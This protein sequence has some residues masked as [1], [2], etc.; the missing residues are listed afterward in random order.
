MN[1]K[2]KKG[3]KTNLK[4][5][6]VKIGDAFSFER[7]ISIADLKKFADLS[8]DQN[9]LHL[10]AVYAGKTKFGKPIAHGM[11]LAGLFSALVG[12]FCPGKRGIYLSQSISF[13][14]PVYVDEKVTVRGEVVEKS[15]SAKIV[16]L[17]TTIESKGKR[18]VDGEAKAMFLN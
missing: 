16:T 4:W 13:R 8:G 15:G 17:K 9:P 1:Y 18:V 14:R 7:K 2:T 11:F 10:D 3:E 5:D 12:N 6:D